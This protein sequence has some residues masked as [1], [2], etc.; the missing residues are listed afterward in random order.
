LVS[1]RTAMAAAYNAPVSEASEPSSLPARV[2]AALSRELDAPV[3]VAALAPLLGGACQDA[4]DV[5]LELPGG[6]ERVAL[7]SDAQRSL[8]GS[9]ARRAE[10][11]V[12]RAAVAAGVATPRARWL[13]RDLVRPGADAYFLDWIDGEA[14]GRRVVKAPELAAAR[15]GLGDALAA[16]LAAIH[17]ITPASAPRLIEAGLAPPSAAPAVAAIAAL[18]AMIDGL[19]ASSPAI[20]LALRWLVDHA[21]PR[22]EVTLVHGDFR[23]GN[24]MVTPA[25][26][27]G[28]LD[29]EFAHFGDPLEDLG[30]LCVRD[31]RFGQLDRPAGGVARR[32]AFYA[33]YRAASGRAVPPAAVH[34][35][36][37]FGNLRWAVG[38]RYQGERYLSG[39]ESDLELIAIA[40]RAAEMEHE[41]LRLIERG[42]TPGS[43]P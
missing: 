29:F 43:A 27:A 18:R 37:V 31:W 36:E 22:G 8:P 10:F 7:R 21:P 40:H 5:T 16:T 32:D 35:W 13:T 4:Y 23:T 25:G 34:F 1:L 17:T 2:A 24:F 11:E 26:L 42:P 39:A 38:S 33:A 15:A 41:A 6:R 20:E 28:V 14:I 9:L 12:V 3:R 30:W 19:P